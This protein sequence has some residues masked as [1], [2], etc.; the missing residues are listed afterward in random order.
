VITAVFN[1]SQTKVK[2]DALS[3]LS[4]AFLVLYAGYTVWYFRY[5]K[6]TENTSSTRPDFSAEWA[7]RKRLL[8][9]CAGKVEDSEAV[10]AWVNAVY[11]KLLAWK[12]QRAM[13]FKPDESHVTEN[14]NARVISPLTVRLLT[15]G[16]EI[17]NSRR[18]LKEY[19]ERLAKILGE[20][21]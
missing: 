21:N 9:R 13:E 6:K 17:N 3:Y 11:D 15:E 5:R 7:E 18:N 4:V 10:W 16:L 8:Q 12:P 2:W 19:G 20:E 14:R 1:L